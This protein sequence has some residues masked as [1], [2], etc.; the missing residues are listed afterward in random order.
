MANNGETLEE[1]ENPAAALKEQ[2]M[3]APLPLVTLDRGTF[4]NEYQRIR[5]FF[6][7]GTS[8]PESFMG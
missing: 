7:R 1:E 5:L 4:E 6:V 2:K 3:S 8:S